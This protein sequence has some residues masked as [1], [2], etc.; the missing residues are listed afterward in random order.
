ME[1]RSSTDAPQSGKVRPLF[2]AAGLAVFI[3]LVAAGLAFIELTTPRPDLGAL[4]EE[5]IWSEVPPDGVV[6]ASAQTLDDCSSDSAS[7][8]MF[9]SVPSSDAAVSFYEEAARRSGW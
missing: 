9:V 5:P 2:L 4:L 8:F 7:V 3:A 1:M 6:T